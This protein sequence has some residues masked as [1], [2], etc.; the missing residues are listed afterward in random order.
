MM[1][2]SIKINWLTL[3]LELKKKKQPCAAEC[4]LRVSPFPVLMAKG[5]W[6]CSDSTFIAG[7]CQGWV[8]AYS[9]KKHL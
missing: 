8:E 5:T 9:E 4:G 3:I 6:G 1:Y 7:Q 2:I